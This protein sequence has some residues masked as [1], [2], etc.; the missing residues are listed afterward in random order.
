MRLAGTVVYL[1]MAQFGAQKR[2]AQ[3]IAELF[4]VPVAQGTL[5]ALTARAWAVGGNRPRHRP[6]IPERLIT[7]QRPLH[8]VPLAHRDPRNPAADDGPNT[9]AA[10]V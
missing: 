5:A 2:I 3:P 9:A 6:P 7:G 4:G 8:R 1:M 10:L